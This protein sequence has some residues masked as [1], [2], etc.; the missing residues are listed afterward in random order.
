MKIKCPCCGYYTIDSIDEI[1]FD[2]C[3][4]CFWQYDEIAHNNPSFNIGAN[5]VS[6]ND[7]RINYKKFGACDSKFRNLVRKPLTEEY[8][9]F[10]KE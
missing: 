2:I 1:I 9:E 10:N 5:K 3:E 7:A 6:L 8:P 4:V